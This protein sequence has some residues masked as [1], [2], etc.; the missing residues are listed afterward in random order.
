MYWEPINPNTGNIFVVE[1]FRKGK[2]IQLGASF[3]PEECLA[4][5]RELV[6][7]RGAIARYREY[8]PDK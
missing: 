8:T 2:W 7:G 5:V 6:E 1:G 3:F 4:S